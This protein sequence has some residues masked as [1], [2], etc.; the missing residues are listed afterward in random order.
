[1]VAGRHSS[2]KAESKQYE[3][4]SKKFLL[5]FVLETKMAFEIKSFDLSSKILKEKLGYKGK[6]PAGLEKK[7]PISRKV[8]AK[9]VGY[10]AWKWG[11][12]PKPLTLE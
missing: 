7:M 1:M 11:F 3:K 5:E 6:N 4:F 9:K 2:K 8:L 10:K 12:S